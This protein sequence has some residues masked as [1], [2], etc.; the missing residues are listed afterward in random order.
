MAETIQTPP[1]RSARDFLAFVWGPALWAMVLLVLLQEA[2]GAVATWWVIAIARD[3]ADGHLVLRALAELAAIQSASYLAGAASWFFVERA[4]FAAYARYLQFFVRANRGR[5]DLLSDAQARESTEPFL[6]GEAFQISFSLVYDIQYDLRLFANV[7]F[8]AAVFGW[9]IDAALPLAYATAFVLLVLLQWLLRRPMARAYLHNQAMANRMT[10]RTYNAWDNVAT[11]N[12]HN[13]RLWQR[14]FRERW[15]QALGAQIRA[16]MLREG[17]SAFSGVLALGVVLSATAWIVWD[18]RGN[19]ALLIGLAATLPRQLEMTMDLHQLTTGLNELVA[20]WS[21]MQGA[22]AHIQPAPTVRPLERVRFAHI[23]MG[24]EGGPRAPCDS[25][26]QVLQSVQARPAGWVSVRGGNGAGKSSLLA[27]LK[28]HWGGAAFYLPAHD[29]LRFRFN[30]Q[31]ALPAMDW[32][33]DATEDDAPEAEEFCA[34]EAAL[35]QR[36]YSSGERQLQVLA[37]LVEHT[38]CRYYLLDEWDA[39][40]D[41]GN[42]ERARALVRTLAQRA[43]VIEVSH[44][45]Q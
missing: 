4:G 42:R 32:D 38:R 36:G 17:W 18:D 24:E 8:N 20:I 1:S 6:T 10:A 16:I 9:A 39:N 37:E 41:A 33:T 22:M 26:A 12:A 31:P 15:R 19:A 35:E 40:L 27:G 21:H 5:T 11:G 44:M 28:A 34:Q 3:I 29:R 13:L 23:Q 2:A 30:A 45:M 25:F 14:D 43:R 7:V